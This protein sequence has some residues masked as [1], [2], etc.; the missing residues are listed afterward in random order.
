MS[1]FRSLRELKYNMLN[2]KQ[3]HFCDICV[4]SRKVVCSLP[5]QANTDLPAQIS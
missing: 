5:L 1:S 3:L 4:E 2:A